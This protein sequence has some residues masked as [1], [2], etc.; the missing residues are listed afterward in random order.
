M[1]KIVDIKKLYKLKGGRL[2]CIAADYP[3]DGERSDSWRRPAVIV[4]PGGGYEFVSRREGTPI[5]YAFLARGFQ[6]FV[7]TYLTKGE[8]ARY[9]EQLTELASAVDYVKTHADEY[10]VN[11]DEV[12]VVGFSAGGHLTGNLGVEYAYA[13]T[14]VPGRVLDCKP[15]ALGLCYAVINSRTHDTTHQHL[16]E[17]F[18]E[19]KK[20]EII[21][22]LELD[23]RVDSATPPA[24]LWTTADDE[25]VPS[26]NTLMFAL[27]LARHKVPYEV[28][29]YPE[30]RHGASTCDLEINDG[31]HSRN[32]AWLDDCAAFFHRFTVE[33]H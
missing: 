25:L 18:P 3:H 2:T 6:T 4:V 14:L 12:F 24:F 9:P 21:K 22:K 23:E 13:K 26:E 5:A 1:E 11:P 27:A 17:G 29:V 16:V 30:G 28:H 32:G 8:G 7:L 15:T 19:K 31:D 20:A 10:C 33:K